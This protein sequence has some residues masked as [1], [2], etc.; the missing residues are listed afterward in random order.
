MENLKT[1]QF[2]GTTNDTIH[3]KGITLTDTEYTHE[4]V[5]WHFHE[6]AYFTFILKGKFIEG[7]KKALFSCNTGSLL[8]HNWQEAHYN[9]KPSGYTRGFHIELNP[10]WFASYNIDTKSINGSLNIVDPQ[11]KM[12]IYNIYKEAKISRESCQSAIDTILIELFTLLSGTK[13][14]SDKKMPVWA[15]L[16]RDLLND[17]SENLT[18]TELA[19]IAGVHPVHMSRSFYKYFNSNLGDYIRILKIQRA[20]GMLSDRS[21]SLTEIAL[22]CNFADQSHFIRSFKALQHITPSEYR[23][24]LLKNQKC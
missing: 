23:R 21:Q 14:R 13:E 4:K 6:N 7:D 22:S 2:F 10:K 3:L 19:G 1:G 5:D 9:I 11:L 17:S 16:I 15:C 12:L 18:L 8:F 20:L 24:L